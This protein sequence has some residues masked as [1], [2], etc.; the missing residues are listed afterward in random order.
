MDQALNSIDAMPAW[1]LVSIGIS[2]V[3]LD[4]LI[5]SDSYLAWVGGGVLGA[6]LLDAIGAPPLLQVIAFPAITLILLTQVRRL[7]HPPNSSAEPDE[8]RALRHTTGRVLDVAES[9][10][11]EGRVVITGKGEWRYRAVAGVPGPGDRV[12]VV[13]NEGLVVLVEIAPEN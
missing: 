5:T 12:R 8:L 1:L 13:D 6:G 10:E 4:V 2:L 9:S 3:L 7:V 11:L